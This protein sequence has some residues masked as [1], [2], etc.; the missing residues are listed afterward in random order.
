MDLK[1]R[2]SDKVVTLAT[3]VQA[4]LPML[5]DV[6]KAAIASNDNK[7]LTVEAVDNHV[8]FYSQVNSDRC[9]DLIRTIRQIDGTLRNERI[10]RNTPDEHATPIWLHIN[11]GGG[12]LFDGLAVADQLKSI[13]T[14]IYSIVEGYSASAATIIS[15]SCQK[16]YILPNSF[17]MIHQLSSMQWGTYAEFQDEMHILEMAMNSLYGVY[18]ENTKMKRE[19]IVELLKHDSWFNAVNAVKVGLVDSVWP[20]QPS[21]PQ[22][23]PNKKK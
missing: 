13:S 9:L 23:K 14:P 3:L 18:E 22:L 8:Y 7:V 20:E 19:E 6:V 4:A 17:M 5:G 10:S 2:D 1:N 15:T 11:S 12:S 21:K 16:R